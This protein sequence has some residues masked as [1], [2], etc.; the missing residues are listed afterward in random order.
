MRRHR[1]TDGV[2]RCAPISLPVRR[3]PA[4][5]NRL[6]R[7][8]SEGELR[9]DQSYWLAPDAPALMPLAADG[10]LIAPVL[11]PA[12]APAPLL[13]SARLQPAP[14][15]VSIAIAVITM[16]F[17]KFGFIAESPAWF[18]VAAKQHAALL[19]GAISMPIDASRRCGFHT[20][21]DALHKLQR[22]VKI[23][24]HTC[25]LL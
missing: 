19:N 5:R 12:S 17:L 18:G 11:L 24:G 2:R 25:F 7:D 16:T 10:A 6:V 15:I 9:A 14:P 20:A 21:Y 1:A 22:S 3:L 23:R 8:G 13:L 4:V